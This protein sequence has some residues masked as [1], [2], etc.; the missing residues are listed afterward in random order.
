MAVWLKSSAMV[1]SLTFVNY[2]SI[3]RAGNELKMSDNNGDEN[4]L[5]RFFLGSWQKLNLKQTQRVVYC[6]LAHYMPW[7]M[8]R[9]CSTM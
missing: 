3:L 9:N 8:K 5:E 4:E 1:L 6:L 2:H 7:L